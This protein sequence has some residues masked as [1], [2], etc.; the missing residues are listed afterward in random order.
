MAGPLL[1]SALPLLDVSHSFEKDEISSSPDQDADRNYKASPSPTLHHCVC[2]HVRVMCA[3]PCDTQ[4]IFDAIDVIGLDPLFHQHQINRGR[5]NSASSK[6]QYKGTEI[7][8]GSWVCVYMQLRSHF[9]FTVSCLVMIMPP[10]VEYK[11]F[12]W[13]THPQSRFVGKKYIL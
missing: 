9:L 10:D 6:Q 7:G 11:H 13:H 5:M 2:T 8:N 1:T 4:E 12:G 3:V